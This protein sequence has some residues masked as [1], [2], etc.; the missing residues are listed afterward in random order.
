MTGKTDPAL[1]AIDDN[2]PPNTPAADATGLT[3]TIPQP[4]D[5][6][7]AE[8]TQAVA[9]AKAE[10]AAGS[11]DGQTGNA[12]QQD[13]AQTGNAP[14]AAAA[15]NG[16]NP[17]APAAPAPVMIPKARLDETLQAL[18]KTRLENARLQGMLEARSQP[19]PGQP[20]P[21][22]PAPQPQPTPQQRLEA[23]HAAQD[24]LAAK[25]DNGEI[26]LAEWTKQQRALNNEEATIR[27]GLLAARLA[28]AAAAP[29]GQDELYLETLTAQLENQHPWVQ[30]FEKVGTDADWDYLKNTAAQNLADRGVTLD[31]KKTIDRYEL[32]KEISAVADALGPALVGQRATAKGIALPG[33]PQ[34]QPQPKTP[35]GAPPLTPA[36]QARLN[37]LQKRSA[38]PP[39]ITTLTGHTGDPGGLPT[40]AAVELMTDDD[41]DKLPTAVARRLRGVN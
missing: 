31:L 21:G 28:P 9:E 1:P 16:Q 23:L 41:F 11:G 12:P 32:R 17:P 14:P 19:A 35:G 4:V 5:A 26:T 34:Q 2:Q 24:A 7:D 37:D 29:Q 18:D 39:D 27:E 40:E 33:Q 8:L 15:P 30:V 13:P 6:D 22:Q 3:F 36:A 25:A 10:E 20:A 38:A